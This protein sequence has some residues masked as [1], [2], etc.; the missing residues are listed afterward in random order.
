MSTS[1]SLKLLA[2]R[3]KNL[4]SVSPLLPSI[5]G[6]FQTKHSAVFEDKEKSD[7]AIAAVEKA[8][9]GLDDDEKRAETVVEHVQD[10]V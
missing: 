4:H 10:R 9:A 7:R 6:I 5:L 1:Y 3:W 8:R 2:E